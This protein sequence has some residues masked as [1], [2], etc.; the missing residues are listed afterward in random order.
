MKKWVRAAIEEAAMS[1]MSW[2]YFNR[3]LLMRKSLLGLPSFPALYRPVRFFF[4]AYSPGK[5][6]AYYTIGA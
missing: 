5:P 2:S 4:P 1:H 3:R 6:E